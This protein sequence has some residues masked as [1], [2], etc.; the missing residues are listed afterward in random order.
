MIVEMTTKL[1]Q[2]GPYWFYTDSK[3]NQYFCIPGPSFGNIVLPEEYTAKAVMIGGGESMNETRS[4]GG[5]A[6]SISYIPDLSVNKKYAFMINDNEDSN[7]KV[8]L[9]SESHTYKAYCGKGNITDWGYLSTMTGGGGLGY[10]AGGGSASIHDCIQG[11]NGFDPRILYIYANNIFV[12]SLNKTILSNRDAYYYFLSGEC[13]DPSG[14]THSVVLSEANTYGN[15]GAIYIILT[16]TQCIS[17]KIDN[18]PFLSYIVDDVSI[19][20]PHGYILIDELISG[21]MI[22]TADGRSVSIH[23]NT[24]TISSATVETAPYRVQSGAIGNIHDICL[25]GEYTIKNAQG[26]WQKVKYLAATNKRVKQYGV[27]APVKYYSV[28]CPNYLTDD[29]VLEYTVAESFSNSIV[30]EKTAYGFVRDHTH[31]SNRN[32]HTVMKMLLEY[33]PRG[34]ARKQ[35]IRSTE[36]TKYVSTNQNYAY[37]DPTGQ[38][39]TPIL[40]KPKDTDKLK[41]NSFITPTVNRTVGPLVHAGI[42]PTKQRPT[43]ILEEPKEKPKEEPK[44]VENSKE[45][46]HNTPTPNRTIDPAKQCSPPILEEPIEEP[47]PNQNVESLFYIRKEKLTIIKTIADIDTYLQHLHKK[48]IS[49]LA[50]DESKHFKKKLKVKIYSF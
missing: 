13:I 6:G 1:E 37:F 20:T 35:N 43:P 17:Q 15:P 7:G 5:S 26:V 42:D 8:T 18:T 45:S 30:W 4:I 46:I 25:S 16:P 50:N 44:V 31:N 39:P 21:D 27:G 29:L 14:N 40:E 48:K 34:R 12:D 32:N 23:I 47:T 9:S 10:G 33:G 41:D 24:F 28:E 11:H 2:N 22:Q 3:Y 36:I 38:R 19:L 49:F